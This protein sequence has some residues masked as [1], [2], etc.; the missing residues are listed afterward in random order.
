MRTV[1]VLSVVGAVATL[2]TAMQGRLARVENA[3][4]ACPDWPLCEGRIVPRVDPLVMIEWAHRSLA[5]VSVLI[6]VAIVV[7]AWRQQGY[8]RAWSLLALASL[9]VTAGIGGVAVLNGMQIH[10]LWSAIDQGT[11][12]LSFGLLVTIAVRARAQEGTAPA[13]SA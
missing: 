12:M 5:L 10:P 2:L 9:A 11:A 13:V 8:A 1:G 4:M 6:V 3:S 7:L